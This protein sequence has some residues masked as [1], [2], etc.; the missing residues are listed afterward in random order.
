MVE[1]FGMKSV[2]N[3]GTTQFE[4]VMRTVLSLILGI[5]FVVGTRRYVVSQR[6]YGLDTCVLLYE[7]GVEREKPSEMHIESSVPLKAIIDG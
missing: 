1:H 6:W 5:T 4:F 3:V 2:L 7:W